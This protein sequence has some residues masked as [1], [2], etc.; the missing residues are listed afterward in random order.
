MRADGLIL[1][2]RLPVR[3]RSGF[4]WLGF[5][6]MRMWLRNHILILRGGFGAPYA[7][8]ELERLLPRESYVEITLAN[9][10]NVF[11]F[12]P[13]LHE[14]AASDLDITHIVNPIRKLLQ[15]SKFSHGEVQAIGLLEKRVRVV[16]GPGRHTH[17]IEYDPLV[18]RSCSAAGAR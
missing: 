12:T 11:S 9:R 5:S 1:A 15:K 7:A 13:M 18:R 2:S 8:L 10:E 14:V 16:H 6:Y 4:L 3:A 17:E